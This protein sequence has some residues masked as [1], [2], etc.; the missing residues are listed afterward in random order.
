MKL[1]AAIS[2]FV[3]GICHEM[4]VLP[5]LAVLLTE[6]RDMDS[7]PYPCLVVTYYIYN[8]SE[9][10]SGKYPARIRTE[11]TGGE[12]VGHIAV[13]AYGGDQDV[14][15]CHACLHELPAVALL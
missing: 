14:S 12:I 9:K 13:G 1:L 11:A 4:K 6:S 2:F 7:M 3:L 8:V 5:V 10:D 15:L